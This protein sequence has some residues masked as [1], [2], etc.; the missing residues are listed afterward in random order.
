MKSI[1]R[2]LPIAMILFVMLAA[3]SSHAAEDVDEGAARVRSSLKVLIPH[4]KVDKISKTPI[5]G[6]YEVAFGSHLVYV[7]DDGKYLLQG[8]I[9]DLE[10]REAITEKREQALKQAVLKGLDEKDMIVFG[11]KDLPYTVTVFTDIDC[12]YCRRLHSQ[13]SEYNKLGIRIRYMAYPRA[14]PGSQSEKDAIAVWCA[15]DRKAALTMAKNGGEVPYRKCKNPV[16]AQ[17]KLGQDF[18]IRGTPALVMQDGEVLPG[19]LPPKRLRAWLV[20][21]QKLQHAVN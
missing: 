9:T 3:S 8:Q 13:I 11:D 5:P 10:T 12:G 14:G 7:T 6:L 15:D 19:Y 20:E 21:Q 2:V 4:L 1:S 16:R 17:Y 18:G